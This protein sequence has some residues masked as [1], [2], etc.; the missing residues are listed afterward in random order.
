[1]AEEL[2]QPL[3]ISL[4]DLLNLFLEVPD[5]ETKVDKLS[6]EVD[7]IINNLNSSLDDRGCNSFQNILRALDTSLAEFDSIDD[8]ILTKIPFLRSIKDLFESIGNNSINLL[9]VFS[10]LIPSSI[11]SIIN[12]VGGY[13]GAISNIVHFVTTFNPTDFAKFFASTLLQSVFGGLIGGSGINLAGMVIGIINGKL[14]LSSL[15]SNFLSNI[16]GGILNGFLG[17]I[18]G[19]LGKCECSAVQP[20]KPIPGGFEAPDSIYLSE[21]HIRFKTKEDEISCNNYHNPKDNSN[22]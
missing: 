8:N 19:G 20:M 1:M 9:S 2:K 16:G 13:A 5:L 12:E 17:S 18:V 11:R 6:E 3:N 7:N 21:M 15:A 4:E 22:G 10:G 14:N